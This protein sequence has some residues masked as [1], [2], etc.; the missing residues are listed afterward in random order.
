MSMPGQL[1]GGFRQY[2]RLVGIDLDGPIPADPMDKW[3]EKERLQ[4]DLQ[5]ADKASPSNQDLDD[6]DTLS[7]VD[8]AFVGWGEQDV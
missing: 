2:A 3:R 7:L 8:D 4:L 6:D 5:A 1:H